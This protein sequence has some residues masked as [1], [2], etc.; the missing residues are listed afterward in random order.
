V[1]TVVSTRRR[2]P[3]VVVRSAPIPLRVSA[4]RRARLFALLVAAGDVWAWVLG[5][6]VELRR[7][8]LPA[9]V[10]YQRLCAELTDTGAAA[11]G[12]LGTTGCR[13][14][15]RRYSDAWMETARRRHGGDAGAGFPRR[16]RRLMPVRWYRGTFSAID[17]RHVRLS[18]ARGVP[19]L[20]VTLARPIP[21]ALDQL[22]VWSWQPRAGV[23]G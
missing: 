1:D 21:Y 17:E 6:N 3:N 12:E 2:P 16:K 20:V 13:S 15:L 9:V 11:F 18:L 5:C 19:E 8:G 22:R 7:W 4:G 10:N 14:V 23:C